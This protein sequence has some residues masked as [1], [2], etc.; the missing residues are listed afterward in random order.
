[1]SKRVDRDTY[2]M[3]LAKAAA[4]RSTCPRRSVGCVAV[5]NNDVVATGYNGAPANTCHCTEAGCL[6]DARGC[7]TR[8]VHAEAN[9]LLKA[10]GPVDTLYCTDQPCGTCYKLA[11]QRGV[12]RIFYT[13]EYP[14]AERDRFIFEE[15]PQCYA[16]AM[17]LDN[18]ILEVT[19]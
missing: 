8:T 19:D 2:F 10:N 1:M 15:L 3:I 7:C 12:T 14:D 4:L 16:H 6:L 18:V 17:P 9:A 11:L 5:L 13:R